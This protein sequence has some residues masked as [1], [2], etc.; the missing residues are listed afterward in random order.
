ML[1]QN[2]LTE[3]SK[4]AFGNLRKNLLIHLRLRASAILLLMYKTDSVVRQ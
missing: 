3:G 2:E 1:S 4:D